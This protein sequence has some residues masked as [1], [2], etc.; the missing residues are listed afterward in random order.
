MYTI[1]EEIYYGGAVYFCNVDRN[2]HDMNK[3][4]R[5]KFSLI[6]STIY[7][8]VGLENKFIIKRTILILLLPKNAAKRMLNLQSR[9]GK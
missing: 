6:L 4:I 2:A 8:I 3:L 7:I 1:S 9:S 5:N